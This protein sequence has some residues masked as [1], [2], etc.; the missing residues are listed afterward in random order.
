MIDAI[1]NGWWKVLVLLGGCL[2]V[3]W[4]SALAVVFFLNRAKES[5]VDEIEAGPVK[6][7]FDKKDGE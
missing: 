7:D 6:V 3:L 5:G 1:I 4:G 2:V